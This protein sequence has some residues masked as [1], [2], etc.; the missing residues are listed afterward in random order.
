MALTHTYIREFETLACIE[1]DLIAASREDRFEDALHHLDE[2]FV[3]HLHT[4]NEPVRRRCAAL[5]RPVRRL[6]PLRLAA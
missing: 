1:E 4:E 6:K 2:I 5:M 3:M